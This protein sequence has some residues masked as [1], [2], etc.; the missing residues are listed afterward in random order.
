MDDPIFGRHLLRDAD[1]T[2]EQYHRLIDLAAELKAA[3]RAGTERPCLRGLIA[4]IFEKPST[5]T[6]CAFEV[7][8]YDQDAHITY[9]DPTVCHI[10]ARESMEDTARVLGRFYDG[11]AL[12]SGSQQTLE[13]FRPARRRSGVEW[14]HRPLAPHPD[15]RRHAHYQRAL[16]QALART[17]SSFLGDGRSNLANSLRIGGA[18]LGMTVRVVRPDA[19]RGDPAILSLANSIAAQTGATRLE[20]DDL[21][22]GVRGA[23]FLYT[24]AWVR[25]GEPMAQWRDRV[26]LLRPY[27]VAAAVL[28]KTQNSDVKFMHC[29]PALHDQASRLGPN[30][31]PETGLDSGEVTDEVFRSTAS[32]VFDQAENRMHIAKAVLVSTLAEEPDRRMSRRPSPRPADGESELRLHGFTRYSEAD[33]GLDGTDWADGLRQLA[34]VFA[35]LPADPYAPEANRFR[36]FSRAVYLPWTEEMSWIPGIPDDSFGTV[37]EFDQAGYNSEFNASRRRFAEIPA[38]LR[39]DPLLFYLIRFDLAQVRWLS[40]LTFKPVHVGVHLVKLSAPGPTDVA[41]SSPNCL[42]QDGGSATFTFVHLID[43]RNAVGGENVIAAPE[44]AGTL[45]EH[46][47]PAAVISRFTLLEPLD[48]FA[49]HDPRVGHYVSPVR[50]GDGSGPGERCALLVGLTPLT[51]KL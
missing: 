10:G 2:P 40:E 37:A 39:D 51:P 48:T 4:L 44:H 24:D 16:R 14:A 5:R 17:H 22:A 45:P 23:D 42:H 25:I 36:R 32:I 34:D 11:I 8:A 20:T 38:T 21:D 30:S 31:C 41:S 35:D 47:P 3:R 50:R 12:R 9:L 33:L 15:P 49:V 18:L 13:D 7:A 29:L 19:L 6:R 27:Q 28:A 46:L 43:R 26:Q 1:L